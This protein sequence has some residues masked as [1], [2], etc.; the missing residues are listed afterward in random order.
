[1]DP[2]LYNLKKTLISGPMLTQF[3]KNTH[4]WTHAYTI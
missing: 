2:C 1:M 3:K 4:F